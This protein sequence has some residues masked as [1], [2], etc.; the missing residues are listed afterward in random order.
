MYY[1]EIQ[2]ETVP[3]QPLR[4]SLVIGK[5][6]EKGDVYKDYDNGLMHSK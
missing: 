2:S 3:L 6:K 5:P 1:P 4:A